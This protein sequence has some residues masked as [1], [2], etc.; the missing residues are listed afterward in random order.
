MKHLKKQRRNQNKNSNLNLNETT[1]L[2]YKDVKSIHQMMHKIL[3]L[4]KSNKKDCELEIRRKIIGPTR[5]KEIL[6]TIKIE[7]KDNNM[8]KNQEILQVPHMRQKEGYDN[9]EIYNSYAVDDEL[10]KQILMAE[11]N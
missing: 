6:E 10:K 11:N 1:I 7:K 9:D 3:K 4:C 2:K 8:N 5:Q